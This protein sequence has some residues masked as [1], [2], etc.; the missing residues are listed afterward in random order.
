MGYS[1]EQIHELQSTINKV[2]CDVVIDASPADLG[3]LLK[4]NKPIVNVTYDIK[5][6]GTLTFE[7]VL[8]N[9]R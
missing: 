7:E 4:V 9:I 1:D 3:K 2:P 6:R 5:E 8:R